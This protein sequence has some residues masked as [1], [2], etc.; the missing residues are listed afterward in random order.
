M[1]KITASKSISNNKYWELITSTLSTYEV[2]EISPEG[3]VTTY[4]AE[5]D[6]FLT[7]DV[8]DVHVFGQISNFVKQYEHY[9]LNGRNVTFSCNNPNIRL[10][11]KFI[12]YRKLFN[13]E[14]KLNNLL[15]DKRRFNNRLNE[16]L[17]EKYPN[18][19]S[20]LEI[21]IDK[22][23]KEWIWWLVSRGI[24]TKLDSGGNTPIASYLRLNYSYLSNIA[25]SLVQWKEIRKSIPKNEYWDLI[26]SRLS[27]YEVKKI[28]SVGKVKTELV[29]DD[30]FLANDIWNVHELGEMPSFEDLYKKFLNEGQGNFSR[31]IK[32]ST[33]NQTIKLE[34]KYVIFHKLFNDVTSL[35]GFLTTNN[36]NLNR[37]I[38]FI[39][40]KFPSLRSLLDLDVD[41]AEKEWI[42]WLN[43]NGI[44]TIEKTSADIKYG[45]YDSKSTAVRYFR[46]IHKTLFNLTDTREEWDKDRW[47]VRVLNKN[48]GID[49][50][51]SLSHFFIN[52]TDVK[53][54][55][56]RKNLKVYIKKRLLLGR[57]FTWATAINYSKRVRFFL[58]FISEIEPSWDDLNALSREQIEKF[59]VHLRKHAKKNNLKKSYIKHH[60]VDS[61]SFLK[62]IQRFDFSIAP[63]LSSSKFL[64]PEDYPKLDKKSEDDIDYIPDFVLDQLFGNINEL[65]LDVQPVVWVAYKTG[66]R[67]SDVLE[68]TQD[69]LVC[70]NG[71]YS[72]VTD[73]EKVYVK[74]HRIPI[75]EELAN[76][77]AVLIDNSVEL[78]NDDNNP[79]KFIFVRY[80]GSR[81]G[82]PFTKDWVQKKINKLA[83]EKRITD[84]TGNIFHFK[85]HQFR[86]TYAVKM[87]NGGAD[88]LT[89]QE[90]LAHASPE[91]TLRYARLLEDT[92]RKEF[93]KVIKQGVFTFD[94]NGE[95]HEVSET[96]D[97]PEDILDMM[98]KDEKLNALDNPY[99]TCRARVN[100]NC[101]LAAEPPCLTANDGKPCFDLSVGM[102]SFD[103][104]KYE[105]L[106]ESTTKTIQVAQEYGREELVKAN[107]KNLDRY[108]NIY[109]TIK[110]GNVIFG[111]IDRMKRQLD[112]VKKKGVSH[113]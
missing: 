54:T 55:S 44:K 98:W 110:K 42:W 95:I 77:L 37:V 64:Y 25:D 57:R 14:I 56:F 12:L 100:G 96:E 82:K 41:K 3:K 8:W 39:N 101:P 87:I 63:V 99:G 76:M 35:K 62:D 66:L 5:D 1:N 18:L 73:I 103:I 7:N 32:F 104:K 46:L 68:L 111:R 84:E 72:I 19:N 45:I 30:Y 86:H 13:G 38:R 106:I 23:E 52:F 20:I 48:Y 58:N 79:D 28:S 92:K 50:K 89:V 17:T 97:I 21:N 59:L 60:V 90:L 24:N 47:D 36:V 91:M 16:F 29:E 70:L 75:D 85:N 31:N 34:L 11:L 67:I 4:K 22:A 83:I 108:K 112:R 78:S 102:D 81:K 9:K 40:E 33:E 27:F 6:Y 105:L 15:Q 10:E 107:E 71:K 43:N 88:I 53:N 61:Y 26:I 80:I 49:Y 2:K 94:L 69:C 74:N 51:P 113:G 65:H 93:E 109:E